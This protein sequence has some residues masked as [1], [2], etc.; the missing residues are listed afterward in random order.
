MGQKYI[1]GDAGS[2][3]AFDNSLPETELET[4]GYTSELL[5]ELNALQ[6]GATPPAISDLLAPWNPISILLGG[7]PMINSRAEA[8][9]ALMVLWLKKN[10]LT[11]ISVS[12]ND[13][14][15]FMGL[16]IPLWIGPTV[17]TLK[18]KITRVAPAATLDTLQHTIMQ[19]YAP[20]RPAE[21]PVYLRIL[22]QVY[23]AGAAGSFSSA[24]SYENIGTIVGMLVFST[25]IP[26]VGALTTS[27]RA[28]R[29]TAS[30]IDDLN[31][32][33]LSLGADQNYW[34]LRES[35]ANLSIL[36][37]YRYWDMSDTPIP[38]GS[39]PKI[40]FFRNNTSDI[41]YYFVEQVPV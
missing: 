21:V 30:N 31:A 40:E 2:P 3:S 20:A 14:L 26:V 9:Y 22:E 8:L 35:P 27:A 34:A 13:N 39:N 5:M 6:A 10:P 41:R 11:L 32:D 15:A 12:D 4:G 19:R 36:D 25:T 1:I 7:N 38:P 37:N 33:W 17:S 24:G 18:T 29:V 23:S 16:R 28:I